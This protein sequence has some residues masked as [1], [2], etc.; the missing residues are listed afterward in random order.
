VAIVACCLRWRIWAGVN[1]DSQPPKAAATGGSFVVHL[2]YPVDC[3]TGITNEISNT[4][5]VF[6]MSLYGI[7]PELASVTTRP[8]VYRW[9]TGEITKTQSKAS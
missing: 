1:F 2:Q 4:V 9:N 7:T 8:G 5:P 6:S 3:N